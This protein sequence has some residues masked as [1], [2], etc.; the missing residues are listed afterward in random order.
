MTVPIDEFFKL[1]LTDSELVIPFP[2][3]LLSFPL[4]PLQDGF[5]QFH[6]LRKCVLAI[7]M[8]F[9]H[10]LLVLGHCVYQRIV[11]D[12]ANQRGVSPFT[13]GE[14]HGQLQYH[15]NSGFTNFPPMSR[16]L[17]L[18]RLQYIGLSL[19]PLSGPLLHI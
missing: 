4:K 2:T 12:H 17:P 3:L 13:C 15:L 1:K 8:L 18:N 9:P 6:R 10:L 14:L 11:R 7:P 5:W 19:W 16:L